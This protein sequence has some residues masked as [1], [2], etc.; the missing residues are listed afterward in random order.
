MACANGPTSGAPGLADGGCDGPF[1]R[2]HPWTMDVSQVPPSC[3]SSAIITALSN[4]GWGTTDFQTERSI[5]VLQGPSGTPFRDFTTTADFYSPDCDHVSWPVPATGAVEGETGYACTHNGDCHLIVIDQPG[6]KLY[7]MW[8][9]NITG[10]STTQFRGGC[11]AVW[12][13]TKQYGS[14][15]R[16]VGCSSADGAGFPVAAMLVN[17]DEV[18]AGAVNHAMRFTLPNGTIR[19]GI[20]VPP[21]THSTGPTAGGPNTPPYGVRLRLKASFDENSLSSQ[22]ARVIARALKK[23]G[24]FLADGGNVPLT[25]ASDRFTTHKWSEVGM[26]NDSALA[27]LRP[28]DFE[29]V[30]MGTPV[31]YKANTDCTRNP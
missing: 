23:Y 6:H 31:N 3:Q 24:M 26:S 21:G 11:S 30:D 10:A 4:A 29:V 1:E 9:A 13:L 27:S 28:S 8:R 7:E 20:Y 2:C 5:I 22:G 19:S 25:I 12:D 16:G 14:T 18:F 17:A 15:L